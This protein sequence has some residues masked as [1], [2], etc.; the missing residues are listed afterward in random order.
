MEDV[1]E[2]KKPKKS[3]YKKNNTLNLKIKLKDKEFELKSSSNIHNRQKSPFIHKNTKNYEHHFSQ[4]FNK[5]KTK[6]IY[7]NESSKNLINNEE[8]Q[9]NKGFNIPKKEKKIKQKKTKKE[10]EIIDIKISK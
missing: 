10:L 7:G 4:E 1:N 3:P 2:D 5:R 8:K 9:E 6:E